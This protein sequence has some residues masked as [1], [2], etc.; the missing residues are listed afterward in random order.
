[1]LAVLNPPVDRQSLELNTV[2]FP[3]SYVVPALGLGC[4]L[5]ALGA[6]FL[7]PTSPPPE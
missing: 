6:R 5:T 2:L 3:A 7:K 4:G 1:M